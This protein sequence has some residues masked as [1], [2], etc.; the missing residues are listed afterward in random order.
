M[1]VQKKKKKLVFAHGYG[2]FQWVYA[3]KFL[4]GLQI[5]HQSQLQNWY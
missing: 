1:A 3:C 2:W 5:F 4:S